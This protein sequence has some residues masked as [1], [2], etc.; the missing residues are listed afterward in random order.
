MTNSVISGQLPEDTFIPFESTDFELDYRGIINGEEAWEWTSCGPTF[1]DNYSS[2]DS[3]SSQDA[4]IQDATTFLASI[5]SE[6]A[7]FSEIEETATG[8]DIE[9]AETSP[10]QSGVHFALYTCEDREGVYWQGL[11]QEPGEQSLWWGEDDFS[12]YVSDRGYFNAHYAAADAIYCF[13]R[14]REYS[15]DDSLSLCYEL[16]LPIHQIVE[17]HFISLSVSQASS[18]SGD[19]DAM[20]TEAKEAARIDR[21]NATAFMVECSGWDTVAHVS[22]DDILTT[23]ADRYREGYGVNLLIERGDWAKWLAA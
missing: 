3:F 23:N 11:C 9:L 8:T 10:Y 13:H 17:E 22:Y 12:E 18:G 21:S 20:S 2:E 7:D 16:G 6:P 4:A 14:Q 15:A 1:G 5:Y 19:I